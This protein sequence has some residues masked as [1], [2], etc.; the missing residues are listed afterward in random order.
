MMVMMATMH[1]MHERTRQQKQVRD[2][3]RDMYE[4][5]SQQIRAERSKYQ[6]SDQ[7]RS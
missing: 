7:P 6:R 1:E 3:K 2:H 5:V 4:V